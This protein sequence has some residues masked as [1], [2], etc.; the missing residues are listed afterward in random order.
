MCVCVNICS[1]SLVANFIKMVYSRAG[2]RTGPFEWL[3]L[4][5]VGGRV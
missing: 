5:A 4:S 3:G 2:I 1:D